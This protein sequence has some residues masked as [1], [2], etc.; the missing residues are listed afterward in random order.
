MSE[1]IENLKKRAKENIKTI[2][3]AEGEELR[4]IQCAAIVKKEGYAKNILLGNPEKIKAIAAAEKLDID[5]IEIIN[6]E[7]G[8]EEYAQLFAELRKKSALLRKHDG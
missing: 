2:V 4:T 8:N 6:P 5:G 7:L 3:L 1:F